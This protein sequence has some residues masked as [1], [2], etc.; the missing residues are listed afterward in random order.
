MKACPFCLG[1]IAAEARKCK[2][3]GEWVS[4]DSTFAR[5]A[6]QEPYNSVVSRQMMFS[7]FKVGGLAVGSAVF[8]ALVIVFC[9][10]T[11]FCGI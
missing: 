5:F 11:C 6:A 9:K 7:V 2:H 4:S 1:E 10:Y 8:T 3:C